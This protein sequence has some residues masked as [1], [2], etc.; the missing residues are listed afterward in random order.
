MGY[1]ID[2]SDNQL[3]TWTVFPFLIIRLGD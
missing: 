1:D 3:I 2:I